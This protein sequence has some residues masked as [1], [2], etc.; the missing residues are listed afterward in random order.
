MV[1]A[2]ARA[3]P[4]L[5]ILLLATSFGAGASSEREWSTEPRSVTAWPDG[6]GFAVRSTRDSGVASDEIAADYDARSAALALTL[7]SVDPDEATVALTFALVAVTEFQDTDG[8]GR[9]TLGEPVVRR[10]EVPGT[11]ATTALHPLPDGGWVATST[12]G[13]PPPPGTV[14]TGAATPRLEVSLEARHAPDGGRE[15]T[16]FDVDVRLLDGWARNGT[17]LAIETT[18]RSA[19]APDDLH[20]DSA[21]LREGSHAL[22]LAWQDG[23]GS[24]VEDDDGRSVT[25]VRAQPA[26]HVVGFPS[27]LSASWA[28]A[29]L[30]A[31][32]DPGG[33]APL[34]IGAAVLA[35]AAFILPAWRRL[36]SA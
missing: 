34:Y 24:V 16:R 32:G 7:R 10:V 26:G 19:D 2:T 14:P 25:F 31:V 20:A 12:H 28:P 5:L 1:S 13:L 9:Y 18:L 36:R 35:A 8:D 29:N 30:E 11:P 21:R 6:G 15:P 4:A 33:S 17:H 22:A 27:A 23:R 3:L